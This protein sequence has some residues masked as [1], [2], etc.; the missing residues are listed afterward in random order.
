MCNACKT[1]APPASSRVRWIA[2]ISSFRWAL[3]PSCRRPAARS[4]LSALRPPPFRTRWVVRGSE[5]Y[6]ALSFLS[7]LSGDPFY[8]DF[9]RDQVAAFA[10]RMPAAAMATLRALMAQARQANILLSP[11]LD[12][13]FSGGPDAT[14]DEL[15][16]ALD[17]AETVF[18][19]S[20]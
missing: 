14:I 13:R 8:L 17:N 20:R 5:G 16:G 11:F 1:G 12:L 19:G 4:P 9:Y 18:I 10:P 2:A 7:P 15:I 6:D 3:P